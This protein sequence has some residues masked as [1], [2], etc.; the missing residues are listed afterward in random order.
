MST[1][2]RKI[3]NHDKSVHV[4]CKKADNV[5][6]FHNRTAGI[7][8]LVKPC[9]V[10]VSLAEMLSCE[11]PSQLFVQLLQLHC[12]TKTKFEFLGY[13]RACELHPFLNNLSKRG[14][15]GAHMLLEK[16]FLVDRFHVKGHKTAACDLKSKNCKYHPDLECFSLL[17][18]CN[19]ECAEQ[20]FSWLGRF[21]HTLK[22]MNQYKFKFFIY[23]IVLA[24]N[25]WI[26]RKLLNQQLM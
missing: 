13:D 5:V 21:K 1:N 15:I 17:K 11:S 24:R 2:D 16:K 23:V 25:Q 4:G 20:C 7:M 22:Y 6:R 10:I 8:A 14:S 12:D 26:E 3:D 9:G 19:T 18:K